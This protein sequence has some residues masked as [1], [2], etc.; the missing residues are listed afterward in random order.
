MGRHSHAG[1]A[2]GL[3]Q[4]TQGKFKTF[5]APGLNGST[6]EV[7]ALY[8][9]HENSLWVGTYKQGLY[10]IHGSTVDHFASADGLSSDE[11][12]NFFEDREGNLWVATSKGVDTFRDTRIVSY[13]TR[14][15]L[16]ADEVNSVLATRDGAV[17]M[18]N[19]EG[20][21]VLRPGSRTP[22]IA[23]RAIAKQ[24]ITALLEDHAG[25]L[26]IGVRDSMLLYRDGRVR[27]ILRPDGSPLGLA[28]GITEDTDHNIWVEVS[29]PPRTV[30]CIQDL[31]VKQMFPVAGMPAARKLAADPKE[32]IWLGLMSGDLARYRNGSLETY[33]YGLGSRVDQVFVGPDGSVFGTTAAGLIAW[34]DNRKQTLTMRNGLPCNGV[35]AMMLDSSNDLWMYT[36]CGLIQIAA[37][38]VVRWWTQPDSRLQ[39]K[40]FESSDGVQTGTALFNMTARSTDGRLWFPNSVVLQMV[41][42]RKL[43][44]NTLA[45]PVHIE[46]IIAG[47]RSYPPQPD[48]RLPPLTHD[49]QIDYIALSF[50]APQKV[51]FRYRLEGHDPDW[52]EAGARR[53]AF[54]DGLPPGSYKFRVIACNNDGVW[55][56]PERC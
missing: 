10:R 8:L 23:S 12:N 27:E 7:L 29:G 22:A 1:R 18:G 48:M 31:K 26:W 5:V 36:Q 37:S 3:Q 30:I 44:G 9:D 16:N 42:P 20:L 17:W 47:R 4:F 40:V 52:Q 38:E 41:D 25:Q 28:T 24:Q 51:H 33:S 34:R 55:I 13:S 50:V 15:G 45:P 21:D 2:G 39:M 46:E 53:Q 43:G 14:E 56:K 32:G 19:V 54:Y 49:L 35:N 11:V 6:L